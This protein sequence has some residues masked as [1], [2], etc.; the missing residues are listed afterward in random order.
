MRRYEGWLGRRKGGEGR[1]VRSAALTVAVLLSA[2]LA[3]SCDEDGPGTIAID[4][5]SAVPLGAVALELR[6]AAFEGV[7]AAGAGWLEWKVFQD[8]TSTPGLRIVA[9]AETPGSF[10]I[11]VRVRDI[12]APIP[13]VQ[14]LA[15]SDASDLE[16][17]PLQGITVVAR[18]ER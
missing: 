5:T 1:R 12:G 7:T 8:G 13:L 14:L 10:A 18:R 17:A 4:V 6:G 11:R 2:V 15:A 16:I 3:A 9:V